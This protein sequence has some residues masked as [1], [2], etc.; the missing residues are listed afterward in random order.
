MYQERL[1]LSIEVLQSG[2]LS[3]IL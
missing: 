2:N 3:F 1:S